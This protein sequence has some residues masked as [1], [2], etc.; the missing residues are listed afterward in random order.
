MK[1]IIL[2]VFLFITSLTIAQST[3]KDDCKKLK[4]C[5]LKYTSKSGV[6]D[7]L[8]IDG[9]ELLEYLVAGGE[10]IRAT[11]KWNNDCEYTA[12][13][14]EITFKDGMF[15]PGDELNSKI[16]KIDGNFVYMNV[17]LKGQSALYKY[18][19]IDSM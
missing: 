11:L 9:E 19:I 7:Y 10:H 4:H 2:G 5:K 17:T 6:S 16:V 18:E 3:T 12:N 1:K 15:K 13:I 8:E 14:T